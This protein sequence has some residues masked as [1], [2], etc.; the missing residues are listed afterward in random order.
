MATKSR[1]PHKVLPRAKPSQATKPAA[2][3]TEQPKRRQPKT[4]NSTRDIHLKP[5]GQITDVSN[6]D[7]IPLKPTG[8]S[9]FFKW[10]DGRGRVC[11]SL[12]PW[13]PAGVI[14]QLRPSGLLRHLETAC[15]R[16][17]LGR[18]I[19]FG[20]PCQRLPESKRKT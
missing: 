12:N 3:Q 6:S 18:D 2:L 17:A 7:R 15:R 5:L 14:H 9:I 13:A 20:A 19:A 1:I 16:H 4:H 10:K 11:C 8:E